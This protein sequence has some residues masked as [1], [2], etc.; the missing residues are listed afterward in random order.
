VHGVGKREV[1]ESEELAR[2]NEDLREQQQAT[3]DVL[4]DLPHLY[5]GSEVVEFHPTDEL[6]KTMEVVER[7][8]EAMGAQLPE[9]GAVPE[10]QRLP[11]H[12]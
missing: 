3:S 1:R 2:D 8:M 4:R 10:N 11:G 12:S 9:L 5:A 7:N 6:A